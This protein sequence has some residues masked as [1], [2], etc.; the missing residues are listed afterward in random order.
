MP[1]NPLPLAQPT[2]ADFRAWHRVQSA[3]LAHD[4]P[5]DP[6]PAQDD[7]RARL[8]TPRD[9][10]RL[11]LWLVRGAGDEAVATATL[12][13]PGPDRGGIAEV[14]MTVH[15]A[16]RRM[17]AGS[18][19]LATVTEAARAAGCRSMVTEV[20]AG[21]SG[22]GFLA[23]RDFRPVTRLTWLRL[24]MDEVPERIR[25]LPDVPHA[26]YRLASWEGTV[27]DG[28]AASFAR[29]RQGAS[30]PSAGRR[31]AADAPWAE[32]RAREAAEAVARHGDHLL[33]VAAVCEAD[34]EVAGY[35]EL[36]VPAGRTGRARQY[37]TAVLPAHRGHG[38][39]L[40]LK[41]EM[42]RRVRDEHP[43]ITEVLA[44]TADENR[45]MLAVNTALGFRPQR[46]TVRFRLELR[47]R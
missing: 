39:G 10:S 29:V 6:V 16:H 44:D 40:W 5:G 19:L 26:G 3:A 37:D 2:E 8:T 34:G 43:L 47:G 41:A 46:R 32:A 11:V 23:T 12:L 9:G 13:V 31:D 22:E 24:A 36:V 20:P 38:L 35:T 1:A 18:R 17:G 7:V 21:T 28:L 30:G 45:H 14:E 27:P 25:K 4:R 42:L 33:A 15:P